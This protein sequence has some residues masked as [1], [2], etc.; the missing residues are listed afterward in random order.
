VSKKSTGTLGIRRKDAP[1]QQSDLLIEKMVLNNSNNEMYS[2]YLYLKKKPKNCFLVLGET[3]PVYNMEIMDLVNFPAVRYQEMFPGRK[4]IVANLK[5]KSGFYFSRRP[6]WNHF[7]G[8]GQ[9]TMP[10]D[11]CSVCCAICLAEYKT[12]AK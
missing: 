10:R 9:G 7:C 6:D 8:V 2:A 5:K 4:S 1:V 11:W 3:F 12:T